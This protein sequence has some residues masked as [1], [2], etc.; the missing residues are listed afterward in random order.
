MR[1][2]GRGQ[3]DTDEAAIIEALLAE[4]YT[5]ELTHTD[6]VECLREVILWN[7]RYRRRPSRRSKDTAYTHHL[8]KTQPGLA[9]ALRL[10]QQEVPPE[11]QKPREPE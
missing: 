10:L 3:S 9:L 6:V 1:T 2:R 8:Q 11:E 4:A 7:E 5:R